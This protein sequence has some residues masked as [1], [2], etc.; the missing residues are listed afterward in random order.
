MFRR[1]Q[2]LLGFR[3]HR[4]AFYHRLNLFSRWELDNAPCELTTLIWRHRKVNQNYRLDFRSN[5]GRLDP[6]NVTTVDVNEKGA[7]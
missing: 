1:F 4:A 7:E 2:Y 3:P 6:V 5:H